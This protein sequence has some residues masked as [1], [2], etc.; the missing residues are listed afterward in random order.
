MKLEKNDQLINKKILKRTSNMG[1]PERKY[2]YSSKQVKAPCSV[3]TSLSSECPGSF[4]RWCAGSLVHEQG[5]LNMRVQSL[6]LVIKYNLSN[7]RRIFNDRWSKSGEAGWEGRA[8]W[9]LAAEY[10][11][12][13]YRLLAVRLS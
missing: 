11:L 8:A 5:H 10:S 2:R 1:G 6:V 4:S 13:A 12:E 7:T 3:V 9:R